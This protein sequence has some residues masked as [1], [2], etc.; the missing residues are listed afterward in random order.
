MKENMKKV[1][2]LLAVFSLITNIFAP[3]SAVYAAEIATTDMVLEEETTNE[4][5]VVEE[6]PVV[7]ETPK[8]EVA[9]EAP[10]VEAPVTKEVV[11]EV[12][13]EA[14]PATKEAKT[15]NEAEVVAPVKPANALPVL[16]LEV[17]PGKSSFTVTATAT[18]SD[19]SHMWVNVV[20]AD[21]KLI[22]NSEPRTIVDGKI[23]F[24]MLFDNVAD[25]KYTVT[26]AARDLAGQRT[27]NKVMNVIVA[28]NQPAHPQ[29]PTNPTDPEGPWEGGNGHPGGTMVT[30]GELQRLIAQAQSLE[31]SLYTAATW[32]QLQTRLFWAIAVDQNGNATQERVDWA[33][34]RLARGIER[35]ELREFTG[36][37]PEVNGKRIVLI[38][39]V[40][41]ATDLANNADSVLFTQDSLN[42]LNGRIFWAKFVL[43]NTNAS[44]AQLI[45]AT[46]R[47]QNGI[48][49]LVMISATVDRTELV[50]IIEKAE[51]LN[52]AHYTADT[53]NQVQKRAILARLV[54]AD[55]R[56]TQ[57]VI[58]QA[59]AQLQRGIDRLVLLPNNERPTVNFVD[60]ERLIAL[61]NAAELMT[62]EA[63][64]GLFTDV[65][66]TVLDFNLAFARSVRQ[67]SNANQS[68]VNLAAGV[69][70]LAMQHLELRSDLDLG[71]NTPGRAVKTELL[72]Q[73]RIGNELIAQ[74]WIYTDVALT[75]VKTHLAY[76]NAVNNMENPS[77]SAVDIAAGGLRIGIQFAN[78]NGM[79]DFNTP[80]NGM[81]LADQ[82]NLVQD[83]TV[84]LGGTFNPED[85]FI[86]AFIANERLTFDQ[87]T[88]SH[89]VNTNVAGEYEVHFTFQ[90][91]TVGKAMTTLI[92]A[93]A[94]VTVT[95]NLGELEVQPNT[96]TAPADNG[97]GNNVGESETPGT[98][99]GSDSASNGNNNSNM[100]Q[101][102]A[103]Y[104]TAACT[105]A[106]VGYA[107][108]SLRRRNQ[109]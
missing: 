26:I 32:T 23:T 13:K 78:E 76:A 44:D 82:I 14:K 98:D 15:D 97:N 79:R 3:V 7:V 72:E 25:G 11:K 41:V 89:D 28:P 4:E 55:L 69:I 80:Q 95:A 92:E 54:N 22:H 9:V 66:I 36:V 45:E 53:W 93:T 62:S 84:A 34:G 64:R 83:H 75:L 6:T 65:S 5:T 52:G 73:I 37:T 24:T 91:P 106:I 43:T 51:S 27:E 61:I 94:I 102:G 49:R 70:E 88:V 101:T 108:V 8:A 38:D 68:R 107:G 85:M 96:P 48:D 39:L 104:A 17:T 74:N 46:R 16:T 100:S 10:V 58:D 42:Q 63:N 19:L 109:K 31:G 20:N 86:S 59:V 105:M 47:L 12:A 57:S 29:V 21:G 71:T 30:R 103:L 99:N 67:D 56:S 87:L 35:L 1:L 18:D 60:R 90:A 77:Q 40:T 50:A 2:T 81:D 33:A